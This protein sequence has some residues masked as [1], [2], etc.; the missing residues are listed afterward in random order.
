MHRLVLKPPFRKALPL[1]QEAAYSGHVLSPE[2]ARDAEN[3]LAR[4]E[5]YAL[6]HMTRK[7]KLY[8]RYVAAM[9]GGDG[10]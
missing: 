7:Q 2:R 3:F 8:A 10:K 1:W 5:T 9:E 4:A 6:G